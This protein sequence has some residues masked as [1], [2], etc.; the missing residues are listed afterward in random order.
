MGKLRISVGV[1]LAALAC[2]TVRAGE[3]VRHWA[4]EPMSDIMRLPD[5]EPTDGIAGGVVR[6]VL[7]K[8]EYEPGSFVVQAKDADLGKVVFAPGEFR[9]RD[10][11]ALPAAA[12][13]L[14]FVK[15]WYQNRNAWHNYFGDTGGFRLCPELLVNDED[16]IRVDT[17]SASNYARLVETD[18]R[19]HEMWIN[20]PREFD[21]CAPGFYFNGSLPTFKSMTGNFR[22]A[23]RLMPV[24]LPK[25]ECKQF[26]LTVRAEADAVAGTYEGAI[27]M[28]GV[29]G[30][31]LGSVPVSITVL[32]FELPRP[33]TFVRPDED[34]YN[35]SYSYLSFELIRQQNGDSQELAE[36]QFEA[37]LRDQVRHGQDMHW[38]RCS[39]GSSRPMERYE[40]LWTVAAMKRAGM[41]TDVL[42]AN[43]NPTMNVW[44]RPKTA[45]PLTYHDF[46]TNGLSVVRAWDAAIGHH[47][48]YTG[49]GDEPGIKWLMDNRPVFEGFQDAGLKFVLA[50]WD[51]I[52]YKNPH[53]MDWQNVGSFPERG[54]IPAK[55]NKLGLRTGWY[56]MLHVGPENPVTNRRQYGLVP[57]FAGYTANCN[58][59]HHLGPYNDD[60]VTY[61]PMVFAYGTG[62]GV[63]DTIQWEGF[64]EGV[65]DIRY[66]TLLLKLA[67]KG[68]FSSDGETRRLARKALAYMVE[69][70][71]DKDDLSAV[72]ARFVDYILALRE[73]VGDAEKDR[74]L[75]AVRDIAVPERPVD[76]E[77]EP[78]WMAQRLNARLAGGRVAEGHDY[79]LSRCA[80]EKNIKIRKFEEY[81]SALYL[82]HLSGNPETVDAIVRA[83]GENA[84]KF[85]TNEVFGIRFAADVLR[86]KGPQD[87]LV[88][89][90]GGIAAKHG[91][92]VSIKDRVAALDQVASV[93]LRDGNE[94]LVR[95]LWAWRK[96]LLKPEVRKHYA[97]KWTDR[98]ILGPESWDG[99]AV[100]EAK[101]DRKYQGALEFLVTDIS[102]GNRGVD[103]STAQGEEDTP[104]T[105]AV[106]ADA[107]GLHFRF[108]DGSENADRIGLGEMSDGCYE[109][110]LAPD[111]SVPHSCLLWDV[112]ADKT[113]SSWNCGYERDGYR[114]IDCKDLSKMRSRLVFREGRIEGYL[115]L[116]WAN[117]YSRIPTDSDEWEFEVLRWGKHSGAWNGTKS[118]HGRSTWGR[119]DF[120]FT[121]AQRAAI[122]R[123]LLSYAKNGCRWNRISQ[124]WSDP[125]LG[126]PAF[127][128]SEVAPEETRLEESCKSLSADAD[129]ETIL[130]TAPWLVPQLVDFRYLVDRKRVRY[131]MEARK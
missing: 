50:G 124:Y 86:L 58:Y 24:A 100:E 49:F 16:L 106:V 33:K 30:E 1:V 128:A 26:F 8:C 126:D 101:L 7:A 130:K 56:G 34:Y 57:Y 87:E 84:S 103:S 92:G 123:R 17:K 22:D 117:W 118:I 10:G 61:R 55:W 47:N 131:T 59:A 48:I 105:F 104:L 23:E 97:V 88:A 11:V 13:D 35:C 125:E 51:A 109:M 90:V 99:L 32:P 53:A 73:K 93:A 64:R 75:E 4:V 96:S 69:R 63:L 42:V 27:S 82:A 116:S 111:G 5:A 25:G 44:N 121:A 39:V 70:E 28:T 71:A 3:K 91:A 9:T 119:L 43:A 21:T 98:P 29:T 77:K 74:P 85:K 110:Y 78:I 80:R 108:I 12:I 76:E 46:Y 102:T 81:R 107:W 122:Y 67:N 15:V 45:K 127:Y 120:A 19:V 18:G 89:R 95:A 114:R 36:R 72:R 65:D 62:D 54:D 37:I 6:I 66:A 41:R 2:G 129:D 60:S 20:P 31:A 79:F 94:A 52:F 40:A 115:D 68:R 112:G 14:K 83:V 38:G 113:C